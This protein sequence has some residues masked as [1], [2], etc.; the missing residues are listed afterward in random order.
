M[1]ASKLK[2]NP[3]KMEILW[4]GS[5]ASLGTGSIPSLAEVALT[6][7]MSVCSLGIILDLG[8][9]FDVQLAAL[10]RGAYSNLSGY[11][12]CRKILLQ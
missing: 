1:K 12:S 11:I 2:P 9:L 10:A 4:V 7:S 3:N 5:Q 8:I 6:P